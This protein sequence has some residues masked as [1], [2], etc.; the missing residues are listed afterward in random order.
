M[1]LAQKKF[2]GDDVLVSVE[3]MLDFCE[4]NLEFGSDHRPKPGTGP[5][6]SKQDKRFEE[7]KSI[8]GSGI[9]RN[10]GNSYFIDYKDFPVDNS[11]RRRKPLGP[12]TDAE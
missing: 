11:Q 12:I 2:P 8:Y 3:A 1:G 5:K 9:G 10:R 4:A 7:L 6:L